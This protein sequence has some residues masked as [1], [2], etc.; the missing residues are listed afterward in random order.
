MSVR[1]SRTAPGPEG[2]K[3]EPFVSNRHDCGKIWLGSETRIGIGLKPKTG[4]RS[5]LQLTESSADM[6]CG[7][8]VSTRADLRAKAEFYKT[9]RAGPTQF[10]INKFLAPYNRSRALRS[11]F[12]KLMFLSRQEP[13]FLLRNETL[14]SGQQTG[15][16][17]VLADYPTAP[18]RRRISFRRCAPVRTHAC[19]W[20]RT[21]R[22]FELAD[23]I[24]LIFDDLRC[25]KKSERTAGPGLSSAS[26][27]D[28]ENLIPRLPILSLTQFRGPD[29]GWLP[30]INMFDSLV[31]SRTDLRT[32]RQGRWWALLGS[33][34]GRRTLQAGVPVT[35]GRIPFGAEYAVVSGRAQAHLETLISNI[36]IRDQLDGAQLGPPE[37]P[38]LVRNLSTPAFLD[39]LKWFTLRCGLH[40][41]IRF[42]CGTN[43]DYITISRP[44]AHEL[45]RRSDGEI[46]LPGAV[47]SRRRLFFLH[48]PTSL[49]LALSPLNS[50]TSLRVDFPIDKGL[51][52]N[53]Y[54]WRRLVALTFRRLF[55][56]VA[57]EEK[58]WTK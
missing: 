12:V 22:N 50:I 34:A 23:S 9:S 6:G 28:A 49:A 18:K 11:R 58:S 1:S 37:A 15:H 14:A 17:G 48:L 13:L 21:F 32:G 25:G 36:G 20:M 38:Y 3:F 10:T 19:A 44:G 39:A 54:S 2:S 16:G 31:D 33:T 46:Q 57:L 29:Q 35:R 7:C 24:Q 43:H 40:T 47:E 52:R 8:Y 55:Y 51:H 5:G 26:W 42:D 4:P 45:M 27:S 53:P 41:L 30:F 56:F